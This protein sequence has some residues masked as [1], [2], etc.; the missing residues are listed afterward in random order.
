MTRR[1]CGSARLRLGDR[2]HPEIT[3]K[4]PHSWYKLLDSGVYSATYTFGSKVAVCD[5]LLEPRPRVDL[6]AVRQ[7]SVG[8]RRVDEEEVRVVLVH[9]VCLWLRPRCLQQRACKCFSLEACGPASAS[10]H[11]GSLRGSGSSSPV[12]HRRAARASFKQA[13]DI[14]RSGC[15]RTEQHIH[16][17]SI[18]GLG[19]GIQH[20]LAH[21][22]AAS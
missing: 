14:M 4:K 18:S 8:N 1:E 21:L 5:R 19:P 13:P 3:H 9:R 22:T 7:L 11:S 20:T 6:G 12:T 15:P 17:A 16:I 2:V 10:Q